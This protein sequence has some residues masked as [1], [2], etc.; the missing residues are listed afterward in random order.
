[1]RLSLVKS[2]RRVSDSVKLQM[3][4]PI[5]EIYAK[6]RTKNV[7]SKE[8]SDIVSLS[9]EAY[10]KT[11][12]KEL[13]GEG[14]VAWPILIDMLDLCFGD[15][16]LCSSTPSLKLIDTVVPK[17][18]SAFLR[19]TVTSVLRE[20]FF[21]SLSSKRQSELVLKLIEIGSLTDETVRQLIYV[22]CTNT[23]SLQ[24]EIKK[25]L[26]VSAK[27]PALIILALESVRP[28]V[29]DINERASKKPKTDA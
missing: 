26:E 29:G 24:I 12:V 14:S 17:D 19:Q 21:A 27:Y 5:L 9:L 7:N 22:R 3:L 25:I 10:D 28:Q 13:N 4:L 20:A 23:E 6:A 8:H 1:M 2:L 16:K 15:G 18:Q 11:S